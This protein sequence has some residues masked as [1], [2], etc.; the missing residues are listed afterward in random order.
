MDIP[1]IRYEFGRLQVLWDEE[2]QEEFP[3]D[4]SGADKLGQALK[5]KGHKVWTYSSTVD[6]GTMDFRTLI[7]NA[8]D[9]S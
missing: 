5:A 4:P 8:Y 9:R 7:E 1:Q 6:V 3:S 2:T